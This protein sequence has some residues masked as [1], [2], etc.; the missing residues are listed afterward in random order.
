MIASDLSVILPEVLLA[1]YAMLALIGIVYT[2]KDSMASMATYATTAVFVVL[3]GLIALTG[4]GT[5]IA[6]GGMFVDDAFARFAKVMILLA[7]AAVLLMSR[8]YMARRDL[9]R[10]EY[11]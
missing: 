9:L 10:F 1:A 5:D 7:S 6:F 8:D 3:A 11:P 4:E 2:G